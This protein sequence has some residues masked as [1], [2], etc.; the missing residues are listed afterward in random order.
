MCRMLFLDETTK[1]TLYIHYKFSVMFMKNE[2]YLK[3]TLNCEQMKSIA[4]KRRRATYHGQNNLHRV[5]VQPY[6]ILPARCHNP[7]YLVEK[8]TIS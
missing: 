7:P 1:R 2:T 8:L 5:S 6:F 3:A 4:V